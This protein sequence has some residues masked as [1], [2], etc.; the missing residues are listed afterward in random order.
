MESNEAPAAPYPCSGKAD[1][2]PSTIVL[3]T[4]S[5]TILLH[6]A[7]SIHQLPPSVSGVPHRA[8]THSSKNP[9]FSSTNLLQRRFMSCTASFTNLGEVFNAVRFRRALYSTRVSRFDLNSPN[10]NY[11]NSEGRRTDQASVEHRGIT[12]RTL[13]GLHPKLI[14]ICR[15]TVDFA[16]SMLVHAP[17]N[18]GTRYECE[19]A[20]RDRMRGNSKRKP[21]SAYIILYTCFDQRTTPRHVPLQRSR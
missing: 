19:H 5:T 16:R 6:V 9:P 14:R 18:F 17:E 3:C 1:E 21:T 11:K 8:H 10:H 7:L 13:A 4:N 20:I 15:A 2:P 12:K